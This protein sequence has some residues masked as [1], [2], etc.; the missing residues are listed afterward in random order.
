M[1]DDSKP[2]MYILNTSL[3]DGRVTPE[4]EFWDKE[5]RKRRKHNGHDVQFIFTCRPCDE[6]DREFH[7]DMMIRCHDYCEPIS[8][9]PLPRDIVTW[10]L[11]REA[12]EKMEDDMTGRLKFIRK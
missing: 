5:N 7:W 8:A 9:V 11:G 6:N 4:K 3:P 2:P 12:V 10:L 1:S